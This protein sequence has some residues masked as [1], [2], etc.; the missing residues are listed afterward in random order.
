METEM[1]KKKSDERGESEGEKWVH[2]L[3]V[4]HTG[5][6]P[7]RASTGVLKASLFLVHHQAV[8]EEGFFA[9]GPLVG[10]VAD[11]R[12]S[13]AAHPDW[14][15]QW[16]SRRQNSLAHLLAAWTARSMSFGFIPF[17]LDPMEIVIAYVQGYVSWG[18]ADLILTII[19]AITIIIFYMGK[20]YYR[21]RIPE[22][23]PLTPIFQVLVAAIKKTKLPA[24]SN[25]ALLYEVD[26]QNSK[27]RRLCHTS[28]LRFL[29]K[30]AIMEENQ[31]QSISS[32]QNPWRLSTLTTVEET[33][34]ILSNIPV[35]LTSLTFGI[36]VAQGS[37]FFV[38]QGATMNLK[39]TDNFKLPPASISALGAVGMIISVTIYDN[40]L[41]PISRKATGNERGINILQRIGI[42]MMISIAAMAVAVLVER[43]R[44]KAVREEIIEAGKT[45]PLSM[46]AFWLAP[47][48]MILGMA[49]GFLITLVDHVTEK[50]GRSWFAQ[51]VNMCRLD[52]FYLL[53]AAMSGLNLCVFAMLAMKYTYKNVHRR[54]IVT[55]CNE[56][57][58]AMGRFDSLT[59]D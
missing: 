38:K 53:L 56:G 22:G 3:S 20:P 6:I 44:L 11:I 23:S 28:R 50:T 57:E 46:S 29:D 54:E 45:E 13:L 42:G 19:M 12:S 16:T 34:L 55:N 36:C 32:E 35:W 58:W 43:K 37:T 49:D 31:N 1:E 15:L 24:P 27:G 10:F 30:A 40:I 21:Y 39:I 9:E 4:D 8:N 52:N 47:Q 33:K 59:C 48:S 7:L 18:D 51:D 26:P 14:S 41:V 17:L 2:D 25:P 5:S